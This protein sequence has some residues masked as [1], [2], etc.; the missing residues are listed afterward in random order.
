MPSQIDEYPVLAAAAACASGTTR[1][2]GLAELRVK[3]SDRL[4]GI[5]HMLREAGVEHRSGQTGSRSMASAVTP[6]CLV[7]ERYKVNW[8][9][10]GCGAL[11]WACAASNR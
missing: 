2:E 6:L 11:F 10:G 4:E 7:G 3:E 9:T 5:C 1:M 8:T